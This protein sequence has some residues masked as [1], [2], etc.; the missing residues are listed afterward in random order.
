MKMNGAIRLAGA[1]T[2]AAARVIGLRALGTVLIAGAWLAMAPPAH[3]QGTLPQISIEAGA[4]IDEGDN[5]IFTLSRTG[6]TAAELAVKISVREEFATRS[7][8]DKPDR[9]QGPLPESVT[10]AVGSAQATLSLP[11]IDDA[12]YHAGIRI[13]AE[14]ESDTG[15]ALGTASEA[16]LIAREDDPLTMQFYI[17]GPDEIE[18]G[19]SLEFVVHVVTNG[20]GGQ[21]VFLKDVE[22]GTAQ[23]GSDYGTFSFPELTIFVAQRTSGNLASAV[24]VYREDGTILY[25]G[26][27]ARTLFAIYDDGELENDETMTIRI[28]VVSS[29]PH[30]IAHGTTKTVTI[31]DRKPS[32]TIAP[33]A[34]LTSEGTDASFTLTRDG[35]TSNPL[36][37]DVVLGETGDMLSGTAPRNVTF[38]AGSA[39]A[40]VAVATEDDGSAEPDSKVTLR[41]EADADRPAA[42]RAGSPAAA[43]VTVTDDDGSERAVKISPLTLDVKEDSTITY[44]VALGTEPTGTV[45]VTP[46][47]GDGGAASVA[48]TSLE[49]TETSWATPQSITITARADSDS[50]DETVM[51]SH[52]VTG[53]DYADNAVPA[54]EVTVRISDA[55]DSS[56]DVGNRGV[57]IV[58]T[59]VEVEEGETSE[60]SVVL[61][62][63]PT[64]NV[65]V[66]VDR[67]EIEYGAFTNPKSVRFTPS[68]WN[69]AQ[70]VI[71]TTYEDVDTR[72]E[73]LMF[74]HTVTGA[75]YGKENIVGGQENVGAPAVTVRVHDDDRASSVATVRGGLGGSAREGEDVVFR[76]GRTGATAERLEVAVSVSEDAQFVDTSNEGRRTV[77]FEP[78]AGA[79]TLT[80]PTVN[81][82]F[83]EPNG[84]IAIEIEPSE[85]YEREYPTVVR[86]TVEDDERRAHSV[87]LTLSANAFAES[88]AASTV[89]VTATLDGDPRRE[90][91]TVSIDV[92]APGDAA[93]EGTDYQTVGALSVTIPSG[94]SNASTNFSLAP[95]NDSSAEGSERISVSGQSAGLTVRGAEITIE[96]DETASALTLEA[97]PAWV[98]E[99][100]GARTVTIT[101]R[102]KG[103]LRTVPT[104]VTVQVGDSGDSATEGTDY[105]TV[106]SL[107][108]TVPANTAWGSANFTLTPTNDTSR[109]G[110]E[111]ISVTGSVSGLTV[112]AT[113]IAIADDEDAASGAPTITTLNAFRV[114][115]T[116][117]VD[118]SGI[119]DPNGVTGIAASARYRW[120]R[121][122]KS[123]FRPGGDVGTGATYTL[124]HAESQGRIGVEVTFEDDAGNVETRS[125][126][127][128]PAATLI[129]GASVCL[130]PVHVAG[131]DQVWTGKVTIEKSSGSTPSHGFTASSLGALDDTTVGIGTNSYVVDAV[132][133]G[134]TGELVLGFTGALTA[135][136]KRT[137]TMHVCDE[138]FDLSA[139]QESN[140]TR[141]FTWSS[142]GLDWS[143]ETERS[144]YLSRDAT[145]PTA[146]SAVVDGRSVVIGFSERVVA[147]T[148]AN[149]AFEVKRIPAMGAQ[150][151]IALAGTPWINGQS[152]TLTL[153]AAVAATDSVVQVSYM[154][155][156]SDT[157]NALADRFGNLVA[158]FTR[159]M[160]RNTT[161]TPPTATDS[162]VTATEDT[163]FA[164]AAS[165]FSFADAN[166]GMELAS[167]TIETLPAS[168]KGTL[169]LDGSRVHASAVV[170]RA[171]LDAGSLTYVPPQDGNGPAHAS[172]TFRVS[173]GRDESARAYTMTIDITSTNDAATGA[174]TVVAPNVFR[175]PAKLGVNLDGIDDIDGLAH[176]ADNVTGYQWKRFDAT[177]ATFETNVGT[178]AAYT[179]TS[180]DAGKRIGV[181]VTF[182]DDGGSTEHASSATYPTSGTIT[183]QA[184]CPAPTLTGGAEL[185]EGARRVDIET[186]TTS[187]LRFFGLGSTF[188]SIDD[189]TFSVGANSY[190]ITT[191]AT[192]VDGSKLSF[193]VDRALAAEDRR[194]LA[195]HI[196]GRELRLREASAP[197][198]QFYEW[199]V[200][201][202]DWVGHAQRTVYVSRDV[203]APTL[204]QAVLRAGTIIMTFSEDLGA[205]ASL[206]NGAFTVTRTDGSANEVDLTLTDSPVIDGRKV[207][208]MLDMPTMSSGT[209]LTVSYEKPETVSGNALVDRFANE[210]ADIEDHAVILASNEPATG[211][212]TITV[213]NVFRVPAKMTADISGIGDL[214]GVTGIAQSA[215]Y[216]W[217]RFD[218]TGTTFE[219]NVGTGSVYTLTS[220]DAGKRI[221]VEVTYADDG[222]FTERA[223][224]ATYPATGTITA[225]AACPAPTLTGG[226]VLLEGGRQVDIGVFSLGGHSI[227]GF[228]NTFGSIDDATFSAGANSYT[229]TRIDI[230]TEESVDI[231]L[232]RALAADERRTLALHFCDTELRLR[233]AF[234]SNNE[235]YTWYRT[236]VDWSGHAQRTVYVSRDVV[237]PTLVQAVLRAGAI[238]MTFSED[239]GAA[240]SLANSAFT[241]TK[242][243]G[244][245][246]EV[247]LTLTGSPVI[248]GREVTL[249]LD[250][251]TM[252][253]GTDLT[254]SYEKPETVSGNALVDKFAN[255]V[256]DIED[257]AVIPASNEPATGMPTITVP[258]VFRVPAKMTADISGIGDLNGVT[259]IAQSAT[260][261]WKRFDATGTTFET[262]VGTGAVYTLTSADAGKRIGVE[263]TYA[264]D[265]GFTERAPSAAY[266]TTGTITAQAACPAPTLTGGAVLL[267]GA[268]RVDIA[269]GAGSSFL[270]VRPYP[271]QHR[272]CDIQRRSQ[273]LLD[274]R[275]LHRPGREPQARPRARSR[276]SAHPCAAL[277]R[278]GAAP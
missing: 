150:E 96:D 29:D 38:G 153:S 232:D 54:P 269:A 273:Q 162:T 58:P 148:L 78:G 93:T 204:V 183:A 48:P 14:I 9:V 276:G 194:T 206:A 80:I 220:A 261:Q 100:G 45:T 218:A 19:G 270:R 71:V 224:S 163:S 127:R 201:G 171:Q 157:G 233:E 258:N 128:F 79:A 126:A 154:K 70:R 114:P 170:T 230:S 214:N 91:T 252:S 31:R 245:A 267:E 173:D 165:S 18:E 52:A 207:T 143:G 177:G 226:A 46:T 3:A 152:V 20:I 118:L 145:A 272:R 195:L 17:R 203:V 62:A 179:L 229:M 236:G 249:M 244:S 240:A 137:L 275:D 125:S 167:V 117:S 161:N 164:F 182:V 112:S 94:A 50:L 221:G 60:Y 36:H 12:L 223:S 235:G 256:A 107:D 234:S 83:G 238:I 81:N 124:T 22:N 228:R 2:I 199:S 185:L 266:P 200:T 119:T 274:S 159:T 209:D 190:T 198:N 103:M 115:A 130:A 212:P 197:G 241:V 25:G 41:I 110:R 47:S 5:A 42:Y 72:D 34:G 135:A 1:I 211:M 188:G 180:A 87:I 51:I 121:Y 259:R 95:V 28:D 174:P 263:V 248:D 169:E 40:T 251:P 32:I 105:A 66:S 155:P 8:A 189:A 264:D 178:G 85:N 156:G 131:T 57:R 27:I 111:T 134:Q 196:C 30:V 253:S 68:N 250:M 56:G 73:T 99:A 147:E 74:E 76:L 184:A 90:A 168:G 158:D 6:G 237:T 225:Q 35:N 89:T 37:V 92:G 136:E 278:H 191:V 222:G 4:D 106:A 109:E 123:S 172:F 55:G 86:A 277:L 142:T 175:V 67:S 160:I 24:I 15:Y 11:T 59:T 102:V 120:Q 16:S 186:I 133:V 140:T 265:G 13:I 10:F 208:L 243:D 260:Y 77:T 82:A 268:R 146:T 64:G 139:A 7:T 193:Y 205:A 122:G 65:S 138:A 21:A 75:D 44:A 39:S 187:G 63:R 254:V 43:S 247:D 246:N 192:S 227:F 61:T 176:I 97:S 181:E 149:S 262:N 202:L 108:V 216:Q 215:T 132:S 239:L 84:T 144:V 69:I 116:L 271:R 257:H 141:D 231:E 129:Q 98:S 33:S 213:P 26:N 88:S 242:T 219:A 53:A 151:T 23:A 255:E 210:V 104:V 101:A 166:A 113:Q 49:F 217:K